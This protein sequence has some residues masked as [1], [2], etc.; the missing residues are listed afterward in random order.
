MAKKKAAT[1]KREVNKTAA[2]K[3]Y[4]A[5]HVNAAPAEVSEELKKKGIDA[6]P[7]YVSTIKSSMKSKGKAKSKAGG[8][9]AAKGT[10]PVQDMKHAGELVFHAIDLVMKAGIKEATAL[11][12]MA[13]KMVDRVNEKK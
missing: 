9:K 3:E 10:S 12:E 11:V 1:K 8:R 6:S 7:A 5:Q 2:I 4:L 13:G